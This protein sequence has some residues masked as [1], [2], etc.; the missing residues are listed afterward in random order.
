M[1]MYATPD[2]L[3][4]FLQQDL[5]TATATLALELASG[6][7][8]RASQTAFTPETETY[9]TTGS[10]YTT[11][12]LPFR[13]V[14]AVTAIR[15][16]GVELPVDWTLIG[17][18]LY[19]S[20]GFGTSA[21]FPPDRLEVDLTHGFTAPPD[22]VKRAVLE[23]AANIYENPINAAQDTTGSTSVRFR[24]SDYAA[25]LAAEYRGPVFA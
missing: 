7:F 21:V 1:A 5:D 11:L 3:A 19:R 24:L 22:D 16:N 12:P 23:S 9:T 6:E 8:R 13:R 10:T 4:S 2:E 17:S 14:T 15:V 25:K 18:T 20:L